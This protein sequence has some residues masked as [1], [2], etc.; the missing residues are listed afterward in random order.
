LNNDS[1]DLATRESEYVGAFADLEKTF[2]GE[3]PS[4]S[5]K[6]IQPLG[7]FAHLHLLILG[8]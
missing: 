3:Q 2:G 4:Q 7:F 5:V 6:L 1:S 8:S